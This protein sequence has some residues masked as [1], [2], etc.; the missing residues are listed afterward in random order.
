M[1]ITKTCWNTWKLIMNLNISILKLMSFHISLFC[2]FST[3]L[4]VKGTKCK[5]CIKGTFSYMMMTLAG[6]CP[7]SIKENT[8][9]YFIFSLVTTTKRAL[10]GVAAL[11]SYLSPYNNTGSRFFGAL[12][13]KT[14]APHAEGRGDL[15]QDL[16][17]SLKNTGKCLRY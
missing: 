1:Q 13:N 15:R 9:T 2:N 16:R 8:K 7:Y 6:L 11:N 10:H 12:H 5:S 17:E 14:A 4:V 3:V